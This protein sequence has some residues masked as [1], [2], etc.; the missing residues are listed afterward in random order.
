MA[1]ILSGVPTR[2]IQRC[3]GT[4][5]QAVWIYLPKWGQ[6]MTYGTMQEWRSGS[7]KGSGKTPQ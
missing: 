5:P 1:C 3:F 2:I 6:A 7:L 4:R